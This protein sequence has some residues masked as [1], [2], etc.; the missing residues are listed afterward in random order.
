MGVPGYSQGTVNVPPQYQG[1][2]QEKYAS[3]VD[4]IRQLEAKGSAPD[5]QRIINAARDKD[6]TLTQTQRIVRNMAAAPD[7]RLWTE[8]ALRELSRDD[9]SNGKIIQSIKGITGVGRVDPRQ[10]QES[11]IGRG[12]TIQVDGKDR[13]VGSTLFMNGIR[14]DLNR[15]MYSTG[16]PASEFLQNYNELGSNKWARSAVVGGLNEEA[17]A[18]GR[19]AL[20]REV[21]RII[22]QSGATKIF[23]LQDS[24]NQRGGGIGMDRVYAEARSKL[25][26]A[27]PALF[28]ALDLA[29]Q[30]PSD[31]RINGSRKS[32][33]RAFRP[34]AQEAQEVV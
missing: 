16:A 8:A 12:A 23:D 14:G 10:P 33:P 17:S 5:A 7:P 29:H 4:V 34:A 11:H 13:K 9:I 15:L 30:L 24:A 18:T 2:G 3:V 31:Q 26:K 1:R 22:R 32:I 28:R 21:E 20:D 19:R 27:H 6:F 25:L